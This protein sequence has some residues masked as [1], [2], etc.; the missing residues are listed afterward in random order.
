MEESAAKPIATEGQY[1]Q[2]W[3]RIKGLNNKRTVSSQMLRPVIDYNQVTFHLLEATAI[4]LYFTRGP[5]EGASVKAEAG[6]N[7]MF[8]DDNGGGNQGASGEQVGKKLPAKT[9][10]AARRV[11][12]LLQEAPQSNEGLHVSNIATQLGMQPNDVFKA[13]DELLSDGVIYTT[14]DDETW[15]V[16]EY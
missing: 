16:L 13:G 15:A 5:P 6:N 3:G 1:L 11:Y 9:S 4:H 14:I 2:V 12:Q 8:V 10:V 7:G